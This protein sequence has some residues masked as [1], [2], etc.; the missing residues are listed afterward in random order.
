MSSSMALTIAVFVLISLCIGLTLREPIYTSDRLSLEISKIRGGVQYRKGKVLF[1]HVAKTGG[2][3]VEEFFVQNHVKYF[4]LHQVPL[5]QSTCRSTKL[6]NVRL[7]RDYLKIPRK[8]IVVSVRDPLKRLISAFNWRHPRGGGVIHNLYIKRHFPLV[9]Q[10]EKDLYTCFDSINDLAEAI[11]GENEC[12]RLAEKAVKFSPKFYGTH[13]T[14]G[15]EFYFGQGGL[16]EIK[17]LDLQVYLVHQESMKSDLEHVGDLLGIQIKQEEV[18]R[19]RTTYPK[20]ND[21]FISQD[22]MKKVMPLLQGEYSMLQNLKDISLN[23]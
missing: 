23:Y 13:M 15:Y 4:M 3:S 14:Q 2:S 11:G 19:E 17:D 10:F 6:S 8:L 7:C 16:Q 22:G 12:G 21:T 5:A 18:P 20:K 1:I 9:L